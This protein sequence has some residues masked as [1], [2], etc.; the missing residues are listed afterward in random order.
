MCLFYSQNVKQ[1]VVC[2][3]CPLCLWSMYLCTLKYPAGPI[4]NLWFTVLSSITCDPASECQKC[5][6]AWLTLEQ[7]SVLVSFT[8]DGDVLMA[9]V[10]FEGLCECSVYLN[11]C[12]MNLGE[13]WKSWI[14]FDWLDWTTIGQSFVVLVSDLRSKGMFVLGFS[15][16]W[17]IHSGINIILYFVASIAV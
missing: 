3:D 13:D 12:L 6:P 16:H 14:E 9:I 7:V 4:L 10:H 11:F 5:H 2:C 17:G 1:C 8:V 15:P